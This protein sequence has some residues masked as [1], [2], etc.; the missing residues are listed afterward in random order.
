[1]LW[2]DC[3]CGLQLLKVLKRL[4]AAG[5]AALHTPICSGVVWC[6]SG[7]G[8]GGGGGVSDVAARLIVAEVAWSGVIQPYCC[9]VF[10]NG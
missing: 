8:G 1:M 7:G 6:V 9:G 5:A 10:P 2:V 3:C 4:N